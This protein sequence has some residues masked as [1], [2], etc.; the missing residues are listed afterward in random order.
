MTESFCMGDL[1]AVE[2]RVPD[3]VIL[4]RGTFVCVRF[5]V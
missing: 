1:T 4:F 2:L 3:S 5:A